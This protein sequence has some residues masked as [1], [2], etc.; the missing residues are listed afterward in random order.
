MPKPSEFFEREYDNRARIA[1]FQDHLSQWAEG[2]RSVRRRCAGLYDLVYG[3]TPE[4]RLDLFPTRREGSPLFVFL[5][6]GYWRALGKSDFS[7]IAPEYVAHG[8][9]V[10]V[11]DYALCPTV[12]IDQIVM[13]VL[14]ALAWLYRHA[15]HYGFG[16]ERIFVGGHSA[17]AHLG[18]MSLCA[19]WPVYGADLPANLVKGVVAISGLYDL[20]PIRLTP[21]LNADLRLD[22]AAVARLSPAGMT[23]ATP[24]PMVTAVGGDE[25]DEYRRQNALIG[26]RWPGNPRTEV[27]M[28]G[29]HH[30]SVCAALAD[31]ASALFAAALALLRGH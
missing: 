28:P 4:E 2:S 5:H 16:R 23:P 31:P 30:L 22:E 21:S 19:R 13:Q 6:G 27:P 18:A 20:E 25:S 10:A 9:N 1:G 24:A 29:H 11:V 15:E 8:V 12:P 17:G 3:E 26:E 14:R 7:F